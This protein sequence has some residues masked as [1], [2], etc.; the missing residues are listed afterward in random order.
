MIFYGNQGPDS[1]GK[2]SQMGPIPWPNHN[3]YSVGASL[4]SICG[5]LSSNVPI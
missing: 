4:L 2:N 5:L 1:G 3:A